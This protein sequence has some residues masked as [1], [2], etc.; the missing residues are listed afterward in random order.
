M[1]ISEALSFGGRNFLTLFNW[2]FFFFFLNSFNCPTLF[3][4]EISINSPRTTLCGIVLWSMQIFFCWQS[5]AK[6][7]L[8][9][10]L[11]DLWVFSVFLC[12]HQNRVRKLPET[13]AWPRNW[14]HWPLC[15]GSGGEGCWGFWSKTAC[16]L[17]FLPTLH[18]PVK[19][20]SN[21]SPGFFFYPLCWLLVLAF[22][23]A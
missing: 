9:S 17:G 19:P 11:I 20:C 22:P 4:H 3:F 16:F 10:G 23:F 14:G 12:N 5:R 1:N 18:V 7:K 13:Q 15:V 2:V 21:P 8:V 6:E